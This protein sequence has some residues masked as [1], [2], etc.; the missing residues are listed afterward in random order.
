MKQRHVLT[1]PCTRF[2][3]DLTREF[4]LARSLVGLR[5]QVKRFHVACI[6]LRRFAQVPHRQFVAIEF[7]IKTAKNVMRFRRGP[8]GQSAFELTQR[9]APIFLC[10]KQPPET[11]MTGEGATMRCRVTQKIFCELDLT[12]VSTRQSQQERYA[13]I[14]RHGCVS[15]SE[16]SARLFGLSAAEEVFT[17]EEI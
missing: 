9:A 11:I 13:Q 5:Q 2:L 8:D 17:D 15:F 12:V 7:V 3:E 1:R 16:V 4:L 6:H 14:V 10:D